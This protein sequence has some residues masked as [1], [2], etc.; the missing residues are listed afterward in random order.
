M[1]SFFYSRRHDRGVLSCVNVG[2]MKENY[3]FRFYSEQRRV[4]TGW[5]N[6][7]LQISMFRERYKF[8]NNCFLKNIFSRM[9]KKARDLI[10]KRYI[11]YHICT[12]TQ[13]THIVLLV[14]RNF[15]SQD[16][17]FLFKGNLRI[18]KMARCYIRD[19]NFSEAGVLFRGD[20]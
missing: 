3:S 16:I 6:V 4:K 8:A 7:I 13:I 14:A 1:V 18:C 11:H 12:N 15:S 9:W 20:E 2:C 10:V 17:A 5:N 19:L